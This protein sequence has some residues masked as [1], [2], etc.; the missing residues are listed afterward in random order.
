MLQQG[1]LLILVNL[2]MTLVKQVFM[3]NINDCLWSDLYLL[4]VQAALP[5]NSKPTPAA[6]KISSILSL[7]SESFLLKFASG[8]NSVA[9][10]AIRNLSATTFLTTSLTAGTS[11]SAMSGLSFNNFLK[12]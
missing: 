10:P 12:R 7:R 5:S 4:R 8:V 9:P 11:R 3:D 6:E 1:L 2:D